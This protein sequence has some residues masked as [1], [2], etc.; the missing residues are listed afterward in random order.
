[1]PSGDFIA[2]FGI[3]IRHGFLPDD[4]CNRIVADIRSGKGSRAT[5]GNTNGA[6]IIDESVRRVSDV[7]VREQT[8]SYIE[9]PLEVLKPRLEKYFQVGL[10]HY[11]RP[12]FLYYRIGDHYVPHSDSDDGAGFSRERKISVV[13]FL[14]DPSQ[15]EAHGFYG[16]GDLVIF[17]L[18]KA[19]GMKGR[20]FPLAAKKGLLVAFPSDLVH[21]VMPVTHG[22]R[23]T[24]V[25]WYASSLSDG[26][27]IT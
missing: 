24:M 25:T 27:Q 26:N 12:T 2:R 15:H 10:S 6:N 14:N 20:G 18:I 1:M 11:Q 23:F 7:K 19:P 22:E 8:L 3:F 16:G 4:L 5:V 21:E 13:I 9:T 17:G